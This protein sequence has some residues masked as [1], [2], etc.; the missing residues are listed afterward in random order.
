[1]QNSS[2]KELNNQAFGI[3]IIG[4]EILSGK[5]QDGHLNKAIEILSARGLQLG[6]AEYV[7]DDPSRMVASFK[8]SYAA[9]DIVLFWW[10]K[11]A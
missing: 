6:W 2:T 8:R 3:Y 10:R 1:M 11:L 5:R 7:G 4:D 9:V